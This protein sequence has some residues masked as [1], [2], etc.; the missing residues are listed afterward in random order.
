LA[1]TTLDNNSSPDSSTAIVADWADLLIGIRREAAVEVLRLE[2][3][4]ENLLL[5][6]VG[7]A[8]I[9]V[10]LRRPRSFTTITNIPN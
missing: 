5:E 1:S 2:S 4:A 3:Y 7:W 9:D 10:M 8:R 6:Y